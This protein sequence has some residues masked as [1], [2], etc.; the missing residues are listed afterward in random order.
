MAH[1]AYAIESAFKPHSGHFAPR[2][3][4][5]C[6]IRFTDDSGLEV[7]WCGAD[8]LILSAAFD[9]INGWMMGDG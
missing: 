6:D 3:S 2:D 5:S 7:A 9:L 8:A 1:K 4:I